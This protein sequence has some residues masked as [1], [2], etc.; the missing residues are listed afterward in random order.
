ML[1]M[2]TI[3]HVTFNIEGMTCASC[4]G[5]VERALGK[6]P[7]VS[8][9]TVNLA[10]ET[11]TVQGHDID[12]GAVIKAVDKAGYKAER[13][14]D[15]APQQATKRESGL[16]AV[17]I[18]AL[19]T[20]P[21]LVP[22]LMLAAGV[23]VSLNGW[24]QFL[25]A[26][27]VQFWFGRRF[28]VGAWKAFSAGTANMD[29]LVALG[30][31]AA[32]GLSLALLLSGG[33]A[34]TLYFE[35]S[36]IIIT[37]IL[38]GKWLEAR[39]KRQTT[40]AIRALQALRPETARVERSGEVVEIP[41]AEL[42]VGDLM[43]IRPSE[44][45]PADG[46]ILKGNTTLDESLLT[47]ESLPVSRGPGAAVTGG[48]IN[49]D[50]LI[51]VRVT[52]TG[53][54]TTLAHI[55]RMV[56]AAQEGKA[57]IQKLVDRVSGI[58]VPV[59]VVIALLTL[60]AWGLL[61]GDWV[62][63][64]L[65]AVA[66][67]VIACPCALGLATPAAI[68]AGTGVAARSGIL[69]RDAEAL[70]IAQAL[71]VIA[72]DKTGTLTEGKPEVVSIDTFAGDES[73]SL[74]IAAAIQ[75]GSTHPLAQAVLRKAAGRNLAP[76]STESIQAL[77]GRGMSAKIDGRKYWLGNQRLMEEIGLDVNL[78]QDF[79]TGHRA[80]ENTVS[81]LAEEGDSLPVARAMLQF[82]DTI[83]PSAAPAIERLHAMGI[84]TLMV[85]GDT[86]PSASAIA[87]KL[88][89]D[90][91]RANVLP[92]Q[93]AAVIASLKTGRARVGMVGDGI[94]DAPALAT[95][96][97]GIAMGSGTDVA[98]EA[99]GITLMHSD[100]LRVVDAIEISKLTFRKI[101]QNLFWAFIYNL[102]GVPLAALGFLNPILAGGIMALSSVSVVTNALLLRY[103]RPS[104]TVVA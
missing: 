75:Q 77:P 54:E 42:K 57:P 47:G 19:L 89:L 3:E 1:Q 98:M 90:E 48:A 82:R 2:T 26:T 53:A 44:R 83:K 28:Y 8:A 12:P 34:H 17:M 59:V 32:Y 93:K 103:W 87:A 56:E 60:L 69:I 24:V 67:L 23:H 41:I 100:P 51:D 6:V 72:F 70:E 29:T 7:G 81:W 84:R 80:L 11:A 86:L 31:S 62:Q 13:R 16:T 50:G 95:A 10:T 40:E 102:L 36:A 91:V 21:L 66:V 43:T 55:I 61:N 79:A 4:V 71:T 9:A 65:N 58:F 49:L 74:G 5:R 30:T 94:N 35:A 96:D 38:L 68:M 45:V 18:S 64:T 15:V 73:T 97:V 63:A 20:I 52:A 37:L 78:M 27:P 25:L 46:E 88:K 33:S 99:A 85:T 104:H 14:Q 39:A 22:M 101:R 92:E 76:I